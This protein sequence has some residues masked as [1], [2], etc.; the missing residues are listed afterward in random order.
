[1]ATDTRDT[2]NGDSWQRALTRVVGSDMHNGPDWR[3]N[4]ACLPAIGMGALFSYGCFRTMYHY[5]KPGMFPMG[6][7]YLAA[8]GGSASLIRDRAGHMG[9]DYA[10]L[11]SLWT[12]VETRMI[13]RRM[14]LVPG[15]PS[16]REGYPLPLNTMSLIALASA[17][18]HLDYSVLLRLRPKKDQLVSRWGPRHKPHIGD[19]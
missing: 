2:Y 18:Y 7:A 4:I 16:K 3:S 8:F 15:A 5:H 13:M 1:M 6:L 10:F 14:R 19:D 17:F 11:A 12:F 9:S